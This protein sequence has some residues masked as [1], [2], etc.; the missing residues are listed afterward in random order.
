MKTIK[1]IDLFAGIGGFHYGLSRVN[2]TRQESET[3]RDSADIEDQHIGCTKPFNCVYS[4]EF[5]KYSNTIYK[6]H[7]EK[8]DSADITTVD[9][10]TIPDHDLLCAGF[11]CQAFS[12]AGKRAGFNDTRGTLFFDV[13]RILKAKRPRYFI[14]ENV[15]GLLSHDNGET[16]KT[17]FRV[18]TDIGYDF[19]WQVLNSK[20]FGVPQNRERVY[21]IG[22]IRG[23]PRPKIFPIGLDSTKVIRELTTKVS[24]SKR[25]YDPDG[26]ATTINALAGGMGAKTGLYAMRG[27]RDSL[28][29]SRQVLEYQGEIS[30]TITSVTKDNLVVG[31]KR[32]RTTEP[33]RTTEIAPTVRTGDKQDIRVIDIALSGKNAKIYDDYNSRWRKDELACTITQNVGNKALRNGQKVW[34]K[35]R[36]RRLTPVECERLQGF[37]DNYTKYGEGGGRNERHAKIQNARKCSNYQ[38]NYLHRSVVI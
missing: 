34:D 14:L 9:A 30:N 35:F 11:P 4:N 27:R 25:V 19:Q 29:K 12:V 26:I 21:I 28:G 23:E 2:S 8:C 13:A 18:L 17:I 20:N 24:Q 22:N 5:N 33:Y 36:V 16:I 6:K 10:G 37:P 32:G 1:F 7:Y 31:I 15:K 3:S 38:C